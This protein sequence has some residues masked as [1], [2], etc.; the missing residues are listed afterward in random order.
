VAAEKKSFPGEKSRLS[1]MFSK[2]RPGSL[3]ATKERVGGSR[4]NR[5]ANLGSRTYDKN[6]T[7]TR[8][9]EVKEVAGQKG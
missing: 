2:G 9:G 7:S 8:Q 3:S 5:G 1:G 6:K 4:S